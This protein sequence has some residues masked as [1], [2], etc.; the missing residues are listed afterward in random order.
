[1]VPF[2]LDRYDKRFCSG[3]ADEKTG[4]LAHYSPG[5]HFSTWDIDGVR[6][7]ALVCYDYRFPELYRRYKR[8]GAGLVFHPFRAG[9][10]SPRGWPG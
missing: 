9:D 2:G 10:K 4:D 3:A 6:C 5:D 1:V 7:G 8:L